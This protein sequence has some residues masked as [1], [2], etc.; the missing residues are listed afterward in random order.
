MAGGAM[1]YMAPEVWN[2]G[3]ATRASDVYGLGVILCELFAGRRPFGPD[4]HIEQRFKGK[5]PAMGTE[6]DRVLARCLEPDPERRFQS[7]GEVAEAIAPRIKVWRWYVSAAAAAAVLAGVVGMETYRAATA[8][9][10]TV[11]LALLPFSGDAESTALSQGALLDAGN[12]MS[13][14]KS[15]RT[16]RL[17]VIPLS[18]ALQ[19][20]AE[21][22]AKARTLLGATDAL[23]G[24]WRRD[25]D[26][27]EVSAHLI[28]TTSLAHLQDWQA[29]YSKDELQNV[30]VALAGMVTSTL[31][32]PPLAVAATVNA[33]A[34]PLYLQGTALAKRDQDVERAIPLLQRAADLDPDSPLAHAKL[35]EAQWTMSTLTRMPE[36]N[37]WQSKARAS[38]VQAE[39]RN[40]DVV[41]VRLA[42]GTIN[43]AL[44]MYDE[45]R[46]DLLRA[47]DLDPA[48][49]DVWRQ[50]GKLYEDG[51]QFKDA[52]E[53]YR[54]ALK[55]QSQYFKNYQAL[56]AYFFNQGDYEAAAEEYRKMR[57]L[58]P[59]LAD[60]HYAVAAPY[61]NIKGRERDAE[62]ELNLA[63]SIQD[64]GK[65]ELGLG[66]LRWY[67]GQPAQAI[68]YILNAIQIERAPSSLY[69]I[70]L[71][72][73][74]RLTGNMPKAIE[75]Y[76]RGLELARDETEQN[77]SN[78]YSL[79]CRGYLYAWLNRPEQA[80]DDINSALKFS[81]NASNVRWMAVQ[82]YAVLLEYDR[83]LSLLQDAPQS[84][85]YRIERMGDLAQ[86]AAS[87]GYK[88]LL[89]SRKIH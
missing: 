24:E 67:E 50:L 21:Q 76:K 29:V 56:G 70:D 51:G 3:K 5:P 1:D 66:M 31:R 11:R 28:D 19:N 25:G 39:R 83:A 30:P 68:P 55:F 87:P 71:G 40:R 36:R 18:D 14:V 69:F 81:R 10:E 8:P 46:T 23:T 27:I 6:W 49:G 86:L 63:R 52:L 41:E 45:A 34:Y 9:Q 75:S 12:R 42:S 16:R 85:F 7:A 58:V 80:E 74:Y 44:G 37:E 73:V 54:N 57:D 72:S 20:K 22:P 65:V 89:E 64:T 79:S 82:T 13:H 38:L 59:D 48:N 4:A 78:A 35:A 61:M 26:R 17:T 43:E 33:A 62:T 84:M 77:P 2:G 60:A 47:I 15:S 88:R 53:A 32:L